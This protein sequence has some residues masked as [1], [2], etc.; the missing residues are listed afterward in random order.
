MIGFGSFLKDYLEYYKISQSDFADRLNITQ[1]HMN[2]I[3]NGKT[4]ISPELM[5]AIS[6][7]T[8]IDVQFIFRVEKDKEIYEE[9]MNKYKSEKE[10]QKLLTSYHLNDMVKRNWFKL[11]LS[12]SPIYNYIDLMDYS[13]IS[14]LNNMDNYLA[15][16]YSFKKAD[17]N[18]SR[19]NKIKMFFWVRHCELLT[20]GIE[21]GDYDSSR[22]NDLIDELKIERMKKF[23]KDRLIKLF[24]K[25]GII[26]CI[27]DALPGTKV[28]G[29]ARVMISTPCIYMTT[30][31]KEKSSFYYTLYHE[32]MHVKTDYNKLK[33]K[34][35]VENDYGEVEID[36]KALDLMID[37]KVY[38]GILN[39]YENRDKIAFDNYIPLC[40]LYSRLAYDKKISY[41]SEEYLSHK[42]T[43]E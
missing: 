43:I 5:V 33:S 39:D 34:V 30:Y 16:R 28:R 31:K 24:H 19:D 21:I 25:Y 41:R 20:K 13:G 37:S 1:K 6:I 32:L 3:I 14:N 4:K 22:L 2:E 23:N 42:E 9:L 12:S 27:E 15:K 36:K 11:K 17:N 18:I 8:D 10:V 29:C 26:L 7:L 40:F 38:E 35:M